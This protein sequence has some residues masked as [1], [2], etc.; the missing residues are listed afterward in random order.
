MAL[1]AVVC[2][3]CCWLVVCLLLVCGGGGRGI[4]VRLGGVCGGRCVLLG[5]QYH[6][7]QYHHH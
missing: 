7:L 1:L 3:W 6:H 5:L 2:C 4:A